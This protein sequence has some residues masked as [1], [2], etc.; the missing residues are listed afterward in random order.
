MCHGSDMMEHWLRSYTFSGARDKWQRVLLQVLDA[1]DPLGT[2]CAHLEHHLKKN[3]RHKHLLLLLNKCDL[4][5][6]CLPSDLVPS[7][8]ASPFLMSP[9]QSLPV[10]RPAHIRQADR[11]GIG[12]LDS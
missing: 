2:R 6:Q 5:C 1:R 11:L 9:A 12:L 3:A 8:R 4:V 10:H 7:P